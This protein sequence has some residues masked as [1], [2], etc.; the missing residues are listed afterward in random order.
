RAASASCASGPRSDRV[1][2]VPFE[3]SG[4]ARWG[5]LDHDRLRPY[6]SEARIIGLM[7][8][9]SAIALQ[10]EQPNIAEPLATR[11]RQHRAAA[12][13][14]RPFAARRIRPNP[15]LGPAYRR[16]RSALRNSGPRS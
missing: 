6:R 8:T 15:P 13:D 3:V 1:A 12:S 5:G 14:L 9:W 16:S 11:N 7:K 10:V 2:C 4:H